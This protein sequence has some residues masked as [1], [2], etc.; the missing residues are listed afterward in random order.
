MANPEATSALNTAM[1]SPWSEERRE[2]GNGESIVFYPWLGFA[3]TVL[4]GL[5]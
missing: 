2:D 3:G 4:A 1:M 5:F